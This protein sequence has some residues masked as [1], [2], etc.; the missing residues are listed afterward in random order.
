MHAI[1]IKEIIAGRARPNKMTFLMWSIA[2]IIAGT[3]AVFRG[4]TWPAV[5][6]FVAG[7]WPLATLLAAMWVRKSYWKLNKS[8]YAF[9][10][11]SALA[12]IL[13]LV[14]DEP[15]VAIAFAILSDW[16]AANPTLV[17]A[18][19][20]PETESAWTYLASSFSGLTGVF[21]AES[22]SF[23]EIAFPAYLF[24][25]M[26]LIGMAALR[27]KMRPGETG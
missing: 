8:D 14:T 4:A 18:W 27:H 16:F 21:A 12:L 1:Y 24:I 3:A 5:P 6:V 19:K 22:F 11:F 7:F 20:Y 10:I 23:A 15:N 9:G 2:P 26:G 13:W 25:M 17:K